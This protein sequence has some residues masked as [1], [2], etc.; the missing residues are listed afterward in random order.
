MITASHARNLAEARWGRGGTTGRRTNRKG[1]FYYSC[2]SHGGFII[3]ARALSEEEKNLMKKFIEPE[4]AHAVIKMDGKI[5]RLRGPDGRQTLRYK[6]AYEKIVEIEIFYAEEDCDWAVPGIVAGIFA[7]N[8]ITRQDAVKTFLRWQSV[9]NH[10][11]V[12][13]GLTSDEMASC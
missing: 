5:R 2:S 11:R 12:A 8:D 4:I 1:A 6:P 13:L 3:D 9:S 10:D 7:G